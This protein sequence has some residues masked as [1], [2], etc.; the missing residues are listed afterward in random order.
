MS[1]QSSCY[2]KLNG[3]HDCE[4]TFLLNEV[5]KHDWN[6]DGFVMSDLR[7]THST[8]AS[9]LAGLDLEMPTGQFFSDRLRQAV[10]SGAVPESRLDDMLVR[11]YAE[12]I[13]FGW[14]SPQPAPKPIPVL[15]NGA[16]SRTIADQSMVLLK[17]D[18]NLLPLDR[19]KDPQRRPAR[20]LRDPRVSRGRRKL[21]RHSVLQRCSSRRSRCR[22]SVADRHYDA[23]RL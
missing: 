20:P 10:Q 22:P 14:W 19:T 15:A 9:A 23:R 16:V 3:S 18:G 11:R 1:P 13:E 12:M 6:F 8:A 2:P 17:N 21:P 4:S 5:L 7:A